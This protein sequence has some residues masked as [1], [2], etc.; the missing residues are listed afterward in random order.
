MKFLLRK[1]GVIA[2]FTVIGV[3]GVIALR[4][5]NGI[6]ALMEKRKEIQTL[7]EF[8]ASLAAD[9][10]RKRA[11]IEKLKHSRAEQELE[12]RERLKLLRPGETQI[13]LPEQPETTP[14]DEPKQ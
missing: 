3:F 14:A 11:R 9:N 1:S 12:I 13:I 8:N 2:L 6:P 5:P 7:Q 4:G 10:E